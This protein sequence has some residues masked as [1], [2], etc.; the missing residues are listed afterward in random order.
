MTKEKL[1]Q[2]R[3]IKK[4][5]LLLEQEIER[6]RASLEAVP[7]LD[8]MPKSNYAVDRT[9]DTIT[10]IV[11]L[12]SIMTDRLHQL[13]KLQQEIEQ[14]IASLPAEQRLLM[15]LRYI[16]GEK[17]EAIALEMNYSWKHIHR[18]HGQALQKLKDD[19]K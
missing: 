10:K 4:E 1:R 14:T 8:D 9:A 13:C 15:R 12:E 18:I 16:E 3:Y 2:Y 6:L 19:T 5:I 11:D 17:W 7:K